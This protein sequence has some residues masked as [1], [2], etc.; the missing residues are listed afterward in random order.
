MG[1]CKQVRGKG[2]HHHKQHQHNND[3][4]IF[5]A[6][7]RYLGEEKEEEKTDIDTANVLLHRNI[8]ELLGQFL[9]SFLPNNKHNSALIQIRMS[10]HWQSKK[11]DSATVFM[12]CVGVHC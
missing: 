4:I 1:L 7:S 5:K 6:I 11:G 9:A 10:V 12:A 2:I 8:C 3:D